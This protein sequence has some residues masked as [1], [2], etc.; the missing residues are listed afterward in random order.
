MKVII[1]KKEVIEI[2]DL[3]IVSKGSCNNTYLV[4][5]DNDP[6]LKCRYRLIEVDLDIISGS[7]FA[8]L[9]DLN[10]FIYTE[11]CKV[12]IYKKDRVSIHVK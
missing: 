7:S 12:T 9:K 2:G 6:T 11:Y 4:I 10:D 1:E 8:T 3:L 5:H